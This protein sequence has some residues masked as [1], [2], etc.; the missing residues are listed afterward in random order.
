MP[1]PKDET[2]IVDLCDE[3]LGMLASRGHRFDFLK[4]DPGKL[5]H[6]LS[7]P[8]DAYYP[9]IKLVVEYHERQH[10]EAHPFFDRRI[11]ASCITRGEQRKR[12]DQLRRTVLPQHG[13]TLVVFSYQDFQH[14]AAKRLLRVDADHTII[15]A[16]LARFKK[17]RRGCH[18]AN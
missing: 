4:G 3:F 13:I 15:G 12:Y 1:R 9:T 18:H 17:S 10:S 11:V 2:Y 6:R 7:L 16:R 8:V 5:G 14:N